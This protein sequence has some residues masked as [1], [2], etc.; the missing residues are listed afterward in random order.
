MKHPFG[1]HTFLDPGP[2]AAPPPRLFPP[3]PRIADRGP[4]L[5]VIAWC[6]FPR[7]GGG[8]VRC[9]QAEAIAALAGAML[10]GAGASP[11]QRR[12]TALCHSVAEVA[13]ALDAAGDCA[14]VCLAVLSHAARP[15]SCA[16]DGGPLVLG[17]SVEDGGT[18]AQLLVRGIAERGFRRLVLVLATPTPTCPGGDDGDDDA[19]AG[20]LT[21]APCSGDDEVTRQLLLAAGGMDLDVCTFG[22]AATRSLWLSK[23]RRPL[24]V[25][26]MQ[27]VS[28]QMI[29]YTLFAALASGTA[30]RGNLFHTLTDPDMA[31]LF[32]LHLVARGDPAAIS[33]EA[34]RLRAEIEKIRRNRRPAEAAVAAAGQSAMRTELAGLEIRLVRCNELANVV[35]AAEEKFDGIAWGE[36]H[37]QES[38]A[39]RSRMTG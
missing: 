10:L 3:G 4:E 39:P 11:P 19:A 23:M 34:L 13:A 32:G 38:P 18:E 14:R 5:C 31:I 35:R 7:G 36:W 29:L 27:R 2:I 26:A 6:G 25:P 16:G 9:A 28:P 1:P 8:G 24:Q 21:S 33:A 20:T 30:P 12:A 17:S 22:L 15:D 37:S